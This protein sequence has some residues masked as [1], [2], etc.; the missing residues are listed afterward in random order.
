MLWAGSTGSQGKHP[1]ACRN[2]I[3]ARLD[4]PSQILTGCHP[5]ARTRQLRSR[6]PPPVVERHAERARR[7]YTVTGDS[8]GTGISKA[9]ST[10]EAPRY[11]LARLTRSTSPSRPNAASAA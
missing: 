6:A 11:V 7:V 10:A 2:A 9:F 4:T 1:W 5:H 3:S 8:C